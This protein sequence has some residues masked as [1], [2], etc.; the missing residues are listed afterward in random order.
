MRE[1]AELSTEYS[2]ENRAA[3]VF[4]RMAAPTPNMENGAPTGTRHAFT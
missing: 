4:V 2:D 3:R 1:Q